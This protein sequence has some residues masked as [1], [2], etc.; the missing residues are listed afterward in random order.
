ME[1]R[2]QKAQAGDSADFV[3]LIESQKQTMYKMACSYLH[4]DADAADAI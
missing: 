2:V 1:Q 3:K 4:R